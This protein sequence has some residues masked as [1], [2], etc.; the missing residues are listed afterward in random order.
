MP[1]TY[2]QWEKRVGRYALFAPEDAMPGKGLSREGEATRRILCWLDARLGI[3]EKDMLDA[4]EAMADAALGRGEEGLA[5]FDR[6]FVALEE[7][8]R[9][10]RAAEHLDGFGEGAAYGMMLVARAVGMRL[11]GEEGDEGR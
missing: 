1:E 9:K 5:G 6:L 4:A 3:P 11:R 7:D 2:E 10:N 8:A